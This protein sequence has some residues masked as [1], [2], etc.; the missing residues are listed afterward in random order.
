VG[1]CFF[2]HVQTDTGADQPFCTMDTAYLPGLKRFVCGTDHPKFIT[3]RSRMIRA[4][5]L[6]PLWVLGACYRVNRKNWRSSHFSEKLYFSNSPSVCRVVRWW[7]AGGRTN[8]TNIKIT[9]RNLRS[10]WY[11]SVSYRYF[12]FSKYLLS[13]EGSMHCLLMA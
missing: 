9:F 4:V 1:T 12:T 5:P 10:A 13:F 3:P 2:A 8:M 6:F 7:R 11:N